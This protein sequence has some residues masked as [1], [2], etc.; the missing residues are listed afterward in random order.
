M[1]L[2]QIAEW[3]K[4]LLERAESVYQ[5]VREDKARGGNLH[6]HLRCRKKRRKRYG[7]PSRKGQIKNRTCIDQW[8]DVVEERSLAG[9]WE[10]DTLL[11]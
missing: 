7:T 8:P 5:H 4:Q 2:N 3:K 11:G 9:D 1:R 6:T 10:A